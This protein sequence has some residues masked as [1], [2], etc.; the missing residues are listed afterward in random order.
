MTTTFNANGLPHT[1]PT[2]L[3]SPIDN[4]AQPQ[5]SSPDMLS[6]LLLEVNMHLFFIAAITF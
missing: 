6:G 5:L 3:E 2:T 4:T 1:L